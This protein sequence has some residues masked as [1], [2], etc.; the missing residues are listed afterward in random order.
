MH[1]T[2]LTEFFL[3]FSKSNKLFLQSK[4]I[5]VWETLC[6]ELDF[7]FL[8]MVPQE[9]SSS[10]VNVLFKIIYNKVHRVEIAQFASS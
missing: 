7:D 2:Y 9:V 5:I 10:P 1:Y 6:W 3:C 4:Y 8:I